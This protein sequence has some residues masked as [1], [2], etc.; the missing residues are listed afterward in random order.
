MSASRT[1]LLNLQSLIQNAPASDRGNGTLEIIAAQVNAALALDTPGERV[2]PEVI[3]P[4]DMADQLRERSENIDNALDAAF[5]RGADA[6]S[7]DGDRDAEAAH[8]D[9]P[10]LRKAFCEG[11]DEA[12]EW[13]DNDSFTCSMDPSMRDTHGVPGRDM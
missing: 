3:D 12:E 10:K 5:E 2:V 6:Y 13:D 7:S 1:T 11:W 4:E 9:H 8:I